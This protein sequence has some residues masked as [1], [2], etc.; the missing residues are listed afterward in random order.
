MTSWNIT[1]RAP[2]SSSL[3]PHGSAETGGNHKSSA[4]TAL[5]VYTAA[6]KRWTIQA[7][8]GGPQGS[9]M[10]EKLELDLRRFNLGR[11]FR[12]VNSGVRYFRQFCCIDRGSP[13][14][15]LKGILSFIL[16]EN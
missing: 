9:E 11:Y 15:I 16:S 2:E 4:P 6:E 10:T 5:F 7:E 12:R 3:N 14:P 8:R 1:M 13:N